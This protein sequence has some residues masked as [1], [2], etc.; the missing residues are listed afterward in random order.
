MAGKR[1]AMAEWSGRSTFNATVVGLNPL[2]SLVHY[3]LG[4]TITF[5]A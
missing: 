5:T 3:Y 4:K 2:G 1:Y